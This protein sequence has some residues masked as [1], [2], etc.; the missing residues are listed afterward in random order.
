MST[1]AFFSAK[2]APGATTVA[3]L[4]ASL[5][6]RQALLAD[7]DPAG[8]DMGLRLP[9]PDGRPLDLSRGML[10]L[11]PVARRSLA[12]QALSDHAQQVL[13]GGQVLVGMS[14]PEQAAAV[15]PL[16]NTIASAFHQ[17][18][19]QDVIIDVGRLHARSP[20][21]PLVAPARLAVCVVENS[22]PGVFTCRAR[23][24]TLLPAL[25]GEHGG[26]PKVGLVVRAD[27]KRDAES[28]ASVILDEFEGLVY[29]GHVAKDRIGAGIFD[30]RPV[31]RPERTLLVRSGAQVVAALQAELA[32]SNQ[33][34]ISEE[35]SALAAGAL[36]AQPAAGAVADGAAASPER[37][38]R[39]RLE[40]RRANRGRRFGR[41]RRE[42]EP[43]S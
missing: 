16:W 25:V 10:S 7:C 31:S 29:F 8:G 18:T 17:L 30:G 41:T 3:M 27:D 22:L 4:A 39:S 13:G 37:A 24:R 6:P 19:D 42:T 34:S 15:G 11:L 14:G 2:G 43:R 20:V 33:L 21:L 28:A 32:R 38:A 5:W 26:G 12:P 1:V 36:G 40:E 23:L 9:A 35:A